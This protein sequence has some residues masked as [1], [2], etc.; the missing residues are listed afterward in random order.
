MTADI[1]DL[2]AV[3]YRT[4]RHPIY[5]DPTVPELDNESPLFVDWLT[6]RQVHP[7]GGLPKVSDGWVIGVDAD[8]QAQFE[9]MKRS[10]IE[11]SFESRMWL[12]SNGNEVEFHGNI[13]RYGRRDNV[14]GYSFRETI[15]RVNDLLNLHGLPPFEPGEKR[16]Y[17]DTGLFWTGA[18]ASRIDITVNYSAGSEADASRMLL[19]LG[20]HHIGR[21]RGTVSPDESTV[22]YGYGSK[23]VSGKVYLKHVELERHRKRRSGAHVDQEVIDF[24]KSVGLLREEFTLKSRFLT[25]QDLCWLGEIDA[26][27]LYQ[28]YRSRTQFQR[29][30]TMD[31]KDTSALSAGARGT[32]ARYEQ[33][34]PHGLARRTYYRH[35]KEILE[36]VGIDIS[37]PRNVEQLQTPVR[38]I[39]VQ[40]LVAPE[41]YRRKY[42]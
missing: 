18:R 35:R 19:A 33:G 5:P 40:P 23:Y 37:V 26:Q 9:T 13:A 42:G 14:F 32:L 36:T 29:F 6:I 8:G 2:S 38:V 39:E 12:R 41:W 22:M 24:C 17:A 31:I 30:R 11:G 16:R 7:A 3:R 34:E 25:Q 21:Q 4:Q 27:R 20:Q 10:E 15:R 28:V 1:I